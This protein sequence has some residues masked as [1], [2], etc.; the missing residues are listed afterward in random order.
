MLLDCFV[1][2]VYVIVLSL[3]SFFPFFLRLSF[4]KIKPLEEDKAIADGGDLLA[5]GFVYGLGTFLSESV[6]SK[7]ERCTCGNSILTVVLCVHS[8]RHRR[9]RRLSE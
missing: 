8:I 2:V 5:E 9:F 3:L 7:R 4:F 6:A 1:F